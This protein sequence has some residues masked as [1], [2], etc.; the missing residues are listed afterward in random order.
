MNRAY[1]LIGILLLT[2]ASFAQQPDTTTPNPN[3]D[4]TYNRDTY[5][6]PV[7][8]MSRYGNW[9]LLGLL[10][11]SGLFGARRRETI[12]HNREESSAEQRRRAS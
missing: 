11:L 6:R 9:G 5:N 12:I 10:G 3:P 7:E 2:T 8:S 4:A 1:P